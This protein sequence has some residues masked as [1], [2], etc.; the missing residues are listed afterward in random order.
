MEKKKE[1]MN[2]AWNLFCMKKLTMCKKC[3]LERNRPT[4]SKILTT[5]LPHARL[6]SETGSSIKKLARSQKRL[7]KKNNEQN[8]EDIV[9]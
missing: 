3:K 2:E 7:E 8:N 1:P 6:K 5:A 4:T 9:S